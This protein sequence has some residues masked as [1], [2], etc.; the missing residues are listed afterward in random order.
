MKPS[1]DK[2]LQIPAIDPE[3]E[4]DGFPAGGSIVRLAEVGISI[5]ETEFILEM[6]FEDAVYTQETCSVHMKSN[7]LTRIAGGIAE[8][9]YSVPEEI[10]AE[11]R[12]RLPA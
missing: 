8:A 2:D 10:A 11:A 7:T 5:E 9:F 4:A 12:K 3:T 6:V 1:E